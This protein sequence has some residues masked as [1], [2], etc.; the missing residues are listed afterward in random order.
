MFKYSPK[1]LH[2]QSSSMMFLGVGKVIYDIH[3]Y[4]LIFIDIH[5]YSLI[6]IDIHWYSLIFIDIPQL[7]SSM[8]PVPSNLDKPS[9]FAFGSSSSSL[10]FGSNHA[11]GCLGVRMP[12]PPSHHA[13]MPSWPNSRQG[14]FD[15]IIEWKLYII[16][17]ATYI[18]QFYVFRCMHRLH[19]IISCCGIDI[20]SS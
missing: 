20:L 19:R 6:L 4:L 18:M 3:W 14:D 8:I 1:I 10:S 13:T 2:R 9:F 17:Y 11:T 16:M 7:F 5:W 15:S 12:I